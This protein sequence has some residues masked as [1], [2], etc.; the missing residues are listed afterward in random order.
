MLK[1]YLES[2]KNKEDFFFIQIGAADGKSLDPIYDWVMN[3]KAKGLLIEP[4]EYLFDRL[5]DTY[6]RRPGLKFLPAA[7]G[8]DDGDCDF[9]YLEETKTWT[10]LLGTF[11]MDPV[12]IRKLN[13]TVPGIE[14]RYKKCTV[15]MYTFK[16]ALSIFDI[17]KSKIDFVVVDAEGQDYNILKQVFN[18]CL[19]TAILYEE[20]NL[21]VED[22][23][24]LR[25]LL[26]K[27]G[28]SLY[29]AEENIFAI[30]NVT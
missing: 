22:K 14:S 19:P 24:S 10:D 23:N 12:V 8:E 26:K 13:E 20:F 2:N 3:S 30:R 1:Q 9:Y 25:K 4:L 7:I 28:Y 6:E 15:D 18:E 5:L 11:T 27:S 16:T 21:K 29:P 17:D